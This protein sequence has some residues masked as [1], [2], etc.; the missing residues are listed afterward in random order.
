MQVAES[1]RLNLI[2]PQL[3]QGVHVKLHEVLILSK[4]SFVVKSVG[5][6]R[7]IV[8]DI[9]RYNQ[10]ERKRVSDVYATFLTLSWM[11]SKWSL[12]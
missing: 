3:E 6:N 5:F 12:P 4:M 7:F 9:E 1:L 2:S 8:I 10:L 11:Q